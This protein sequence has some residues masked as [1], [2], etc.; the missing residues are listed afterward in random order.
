MKKTTLVSRRNFLTTTAIASSSLLVT[1]NAFNKNLFFNQTFA[2][3]QHLEIYIFSKHLQFLNYKDM[4]EASKEMGFDGID[5]TIRPNGHVNPTMVIDQLP[6][7]T[8]F[9]KSYQLQPKII[10][11]NIIDADKSL[12]ILTSNISDA[13]KKT[14]ENKIIKLQLNLVESST[15]FI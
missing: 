9:M 8:E 12:E 6:L 11:T 1:P 2:L 3:N 7:A 5:L 15:N 10:T 14:A 13:D 4:C